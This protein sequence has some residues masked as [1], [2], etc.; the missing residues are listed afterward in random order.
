VH[1]CC[2]ACACCHSMLPAYDD[3][4]PPA[5]RV[6]TALA[7]TE[8]VHGLK[9]VDYKLPRGSML[10]EVGGTVGAADPFFNNQC[11][12]AIHFGAAIPLGLWNHS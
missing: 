11:A 1:P 7:A 4:C 3:L 5:W 2:A 9:Y 8:E 6:T 10:M 12:C